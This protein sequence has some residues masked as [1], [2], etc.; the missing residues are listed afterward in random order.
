MLPSEA[1]DVT[2]TFQPDPK[3]FLGNTSRR[4]E[5]SVGNI[6]MVETLFKLVAYFNENTVPSS[7]KF[8]NILCLKVLKF[9]W[10]SEPFHVFVVQW[11]HSS[12]HYHLVHGVY[13]ILKQ[14]RRDTSYRKSSN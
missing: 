14:A 9:S 13:N 1:K 2:G 4:A 5:I 3:L 8:P 7:F 12:V 10:L 11:E 6:T